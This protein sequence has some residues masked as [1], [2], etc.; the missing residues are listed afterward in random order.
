[1][2]EI[3]RAAENGS[4]LIRQLLALARCRPVETCCL[5]LNEVVEG[6]VDFLSHLIGENIELVTV[7][8]EDLGLVEMDRSQVEQM[9]LNLVLNAR[10]AMPEGGRITLATRNCF[11]ALPGSNGHNSSVL[12][13]CIE[14]TV[15]DTGWGMDPETKARLFEPFFTTKEFGKGN[16]LG[17]TT[18]HNIV[19][20]SA[21]TICIDS[22]PGKGTRAAIRIPRIDPM[23]PQ[24]L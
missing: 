4:N 21:G 2:E 11:C 23:L 17:L 6:A 3:R 9:I 14:L 12:V 18:T 19:K 10:D 13:S 8:A 24:N 5:S 16:G 7:L 1:V 22:E 20:G 15:T